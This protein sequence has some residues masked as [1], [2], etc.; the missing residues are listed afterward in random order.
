[1]SNRVLNQLAHLELIT[2]KLEESTAFF[3]D[4][5]GL[6]EVAREGS[7]VY[8]RC[9][10]DYYHHSVVLTEGDEPALGHA[11]WRTESAEDLERAVAQIE[12]AGI[13]GEWVDGSVGHGRSYRFAAPRGHV[14]ELFWEVERYKAPPELASPYP[15]RPQR[16]TR[17]G[18]APRQLDHVTI[19]T[20]D[21]MGD[22]SWYRDHLGFRFMAWNGLD[23]DPS[24]VV[25]AV[26]TTNEK[27]HDL[28]L[29]IDLS[30]IPGRL[31]HFAFWVD[32]R[33]E[34]LL[35]A[36]TLI[37]AG[38]PVEFGPGKHGIGEQN[39]LYFREPGGLRIEINTGGYRN[40][41]PDW[42]PVEWRPSQGSNTMY[43]NVAMPDSMM[44][45]FPPHEQGAVP[46]LGAQPVGAHAGGIENP[47]GA[48][49]AA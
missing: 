29:A 49:G 1:M 28:G 17:R 37:E 15:E 7:S 9:W 40:Y 46:E 20:S 44:E 43:R 34:L 30:P 12:A 5:M 41:V 22:A 45:A 32:S 18:I 26:V 8:L 36:E 19:A 25:F 47:W 14:I 23:H 39:Y 38:T 31:H 21:V 42:E 13:S 16:Q 48:P 24:I 4:V 27:S 11:A 3:T 2:P 10:G 33:D 35:A 6:T